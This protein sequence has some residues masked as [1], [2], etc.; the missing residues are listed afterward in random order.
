VGEAEQS[1]LAGH[2]REKDRDEKKKKD[3]NE[4][5]DDVFEDIKR[6]RKEKIRRSKQAERK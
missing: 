6:P 4:K 1:P 2:Y 5:T 3:T